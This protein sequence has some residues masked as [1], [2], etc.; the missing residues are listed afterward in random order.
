[1]ISFF[2]TT[3][4]GSHAPQSVFLASGSWIIEKMHPLSSMAL[5]HFMS[6][7]DLEKPLNFN[8]RSSP[9]SALIDF[10][11]II[12]GDERKRISS[13]ARTH[14]R[15]W[16]QIRWF[17]I[18]VSFTAE[19]NKIKMHGFN[20]LSGERNFF[21]FFGQLMHIPEAHLS[22][23]RDR[24]DAS[25]SLSAYERKRDLRRLCVRR[26]HFAFHYRHFSL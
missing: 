23:L 3:H 10:P 24:N 14:A 5:K 17:Q 21:F 11:V 19:K 15:R 18:R 7:S 16:S 8:R 26:R 4:P 12:G 22:F 6:A 1:M 25:L 9:R 2:W 13:D 20:G